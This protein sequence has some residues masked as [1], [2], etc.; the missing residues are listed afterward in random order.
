MAITEICFDPDTWEA[1][2]TLPLTESTASAEWAVTV[3]SDTQGPL[4][5]ANDAPTFPG[6]TGIHSPPAVNDLYSIGDETGSFMVAKRVR[7]RK[8]SVNRRWR[9]A[10]SFG[11]RGSLLAGDENVNPLSRPTKWWIE[12]QTDS[13]VAVKDRAGAVIANSAKQPFVPGLEIPKHSCVIVAQKNMSVTIGGFFA[14]FDQWI[15]RNGKTNSDTWNGFPIDTLLTRPFRTG[16]PTAENN[17]EYYSMVWRFAFNPDT[18]RETPV[19]QGWQHLVGGNLKKV[20][21]DQGFG[22]AEPFLLNG[23]DGTKQPDGSLGVLLDG[24][25]GRQGPIYPFPQEAFVGLPL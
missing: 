14:L 4:S 3:D 22:P 19:D 25:A 13:E 5:I 8:T 2:L 24:L 23:I 9:Y 6:A 17:V 1:D 7:V 10:V 20:D 15:G 21:D 16:Q 11:E 12:S 18:W